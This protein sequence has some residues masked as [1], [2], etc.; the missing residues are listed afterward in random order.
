MDCANCGKKTPLSK[1][2]H[3]ARW[4]KP[5]KFCCD[6]CIMAYYQAKHQSYMA[7]HPTEAFAEASALNTR[8]MFQYRV[9]RLDA[10]IAEHRLQLD[11]LLTQREIE[12]EAFR[13]EF[14]KDITEVKR[15]RPPK[16]HDFRSPVSRLQ[17][18]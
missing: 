13:A 1:S 2:P 18:R 9:S 10:K 17:H 4:G 11:R 5:R 3:R 8:R 14:G 7:D 16:I 12:C 6:R 15:G